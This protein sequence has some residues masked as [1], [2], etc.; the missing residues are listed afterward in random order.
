VHGAALLTALTALSRTAWAALAD[1]S[2]SS[3]IFWIS[4]LT[5]TLAFTAEFTA[6]ILCVFPMPQSDAVT[7]ITEVALARDT[8]T[9]TVAPWPGFRGCRLHLY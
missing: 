5:V 3:F 9:P 1:L 8:L 4:A 2:I 6:V 7:G